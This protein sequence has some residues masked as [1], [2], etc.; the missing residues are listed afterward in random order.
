MFLHHLCDNPR[1]ALVPNI[2]QPL[3]VVDEGNLLPTCGVYQY[4]TEVTLNQDIR[5]REP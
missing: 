2:L 1:G 5:D 3:H 4:T